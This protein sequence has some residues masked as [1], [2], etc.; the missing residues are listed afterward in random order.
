MTNTKWIIEFHI[1][2]I[3]G[4]NPKGV[5]YSDKETEEEAM[6]ELDERYM[7]EPT[8]D[9]VNF[10]GWDGSGDEELIIDKIFKP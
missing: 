9:L 7:N 4:T 1:S 2:T 3:D 6:T 5:F 10:D 8:S